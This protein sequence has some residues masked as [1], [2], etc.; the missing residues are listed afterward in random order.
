M[1]SA[2]ENETMTRVGPGTPM[3]ELMR[4][5]WVPAA[6]SRELPES[7]GPP[8]RVRLLG[9]RLVAFRDT[10]GRLGLV[11]EF[12]P[13]RRASLFLGRNEE[14]G[15]RCVYH[16]WKFDVAGN[17]LDMLNLPSDTT[18]KTKIHLKAYPTVERGGIVWAYLG[19]PEK[20][21]PLPL[22]NGRNCRKPIA[23]CK[24]PGKNATGYRPWKAALTQAMR[25]FFI[26]PSIPPPKSRAALEECG[27]MPGLRAAKK[28]S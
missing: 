9:E 17:C 12:C 27:R 2:E 7:D 8:I 16:G 23:S 28:S 10:S 19:P 13:H 22:L 21:P 26:A 5:Y 15:L 6:L 24:K 4:R 20:R 14:D 25:R 11:D 1:L 18:F 3:G